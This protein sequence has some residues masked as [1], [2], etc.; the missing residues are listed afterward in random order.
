MKKIPLYLLLLA[1]YPC[2]SLYALNLTEMSLIDVVRPL[3]AS[4]LVIGILFAV[5]L[6]FTRKV[7]QAAIA[8]GIVFLV[9]SSYG[10]FYNVA[11]T[12]QVWGIAIGRHRTI[13]P[14]IVLL[15]CI[16]GWLLFKAKSNN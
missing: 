2:I 10:A 12:W 4:W 1:S 5:L 9:I 3:V 14:V 16:G 11:R 15:L 6:A 7:G 13:L 8:A